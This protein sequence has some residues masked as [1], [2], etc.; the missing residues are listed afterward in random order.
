MAKLLQSKPIEPCKTALI[1]GAG[2]LDHYVLTPEGSHVS[3]HRSKNLWV[4]ICKS[5]NI[6]VLICKSL[7]PDVSC[8]EFWF[9][10]CVPIT[11]SWPYCFLKTWVSTEFCNVFAMKIAIIW[12][13]SEKILSNCQFWSDLYNFCV[14][15][16]IFS[17]KFEW[18]IQIFQFL[19]WGVMGST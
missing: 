6:T 17:K 18:H 2:H 13:L 10:F 11:N 14:K 16:F 15:I 12:S 5:L 4:F 1:E 19:P 8:C 7:N 3:N 9:W